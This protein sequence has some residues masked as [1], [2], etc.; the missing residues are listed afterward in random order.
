[1][2]DLRIDCRLLFEAGAR[3]VGSISRRTMDESLDKHASP[4]GGV[5]AAIGGAVLAAL[6][7]SEELNVADLFQPA[8]VLFNF[9]CQR[10]LSFPYSESHSQKNVFFN[11]WACSIAEDLL[12]YVV[13]ENSK[14]S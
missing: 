1:M 6:D 3:A 2:I 5:H 7:L 10:L 4:V 13:G 9:L 11:L 14:H 8:S 12:F